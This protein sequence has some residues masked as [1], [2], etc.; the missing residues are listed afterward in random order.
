MI[1]VIYLSI[2]GIGAV[3]L[4]LDAY[5]YGKLRRAFLAACNQR[6]IEI[7]ARENANIAIARKD[8]V[9]STLRCNEMSNLATIQALRKEIA[10][11]AAREQKHAAFIALARKWAG[12]IREGLGINKAVSIEHVRPTRELNAA[13]RTA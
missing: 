11:M 4:I 10:S 1:H 13:R 9:I 2:I 7:K 12:P 8:D 5:E 3:I 6:G